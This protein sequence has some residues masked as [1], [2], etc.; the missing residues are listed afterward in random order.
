MSETIDRL[1]ARVQQLERRLRRH[2]RIGG[3]A[4]LLA[5]L[6]A[7]AA[8]LAQGRRA[9]FKEVDLERLNVV[10][11]DGQLVLAMANTARLPHPL[12]AGKSVKTDRTGPGLIFF[13]GKGWEVGGLIYGTEPTRGGYQAGGQ[14]SLDQFRNDQVVYL[15]YE[16]DGTTNKSAGLYVVDRA[17][18]P[19]LDEQMRMQETLKSA[20]EDARVAL[21]AKL[22]A[23][24][25]PRVFVGSENETAM[26]RLRDR[27]GRDRIRLIVDPQGDARIE[28]V[29]ESGKVVD[30]LPK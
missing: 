22:R 28:F 20:T 23:A 13:D 9:R 10:E 12:I 14:F 30:R 6:F 17:R 5:A 19:T 15:R 16:D 2:Q 3:V 29:D 24:K 11:P 18:T 7:G 27:A 26:V 4:V 1:E 8:F 21:E 25:A